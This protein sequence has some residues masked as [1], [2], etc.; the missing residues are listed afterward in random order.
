MN[1]NLIALIG[2]IIFCAGCN[3]KAD[4]VV[5]N[6]S[7]E[8]VDSVLV[9]PD[10]SATKRYFTLAPGQSKKVSID[11]SELGDGAYGIMYKMNSV[12][13]DFSFGYFSNG[14]VLE[15]EHNVFI[16]SDTVYYIAK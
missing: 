3:N 10:R 2:F 16:K 8:T 14:N 4:L 13:K 15:G 5:L 6:Q 1:K 11:I 7:T 9:Q 12:K